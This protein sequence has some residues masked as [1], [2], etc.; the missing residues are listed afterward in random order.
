VSQR[1]WQVQVA[2]AEYQTVVGQLV[3]ENG[4]LVFYDSAG[5]I[6]IAYSRRAWL[7]VCPEEDDQS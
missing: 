7:T 2:Y 6:S 1:T 3:I 5:R 4:A